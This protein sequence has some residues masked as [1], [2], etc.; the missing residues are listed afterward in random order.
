MQQMGGDSSGI[1][2]DEDSVG[3]C[4]GDVKSSSGGGGGGG[5]GSSGSV[6]SGKGRVE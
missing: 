2:N 4:D 6:K 3:G 1:D 5:G